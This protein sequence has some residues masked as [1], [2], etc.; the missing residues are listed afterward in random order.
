MKFRYYLRGIGFGIIFAALVFLVAFNTNKTGNLSDDEIRERAKK[1]G[2][3]EADAP[4]KDLINSDKK[5]DS[6]DADTAENSSD[7]QTAADNTTTTEQTATKT[8]TESTTATEQ[9]STKTEA[10]KTTA[11]E[12]TTKETSTEKVTT[13]QQTTEQTTTSEDNKKEKSDDKK[14]DSKTDKEKQVEITINKGS[15]SYPVC[16]KLQ[17]LGMIDDAAKFDDY[18]IE[19]GYANRI[20][21][22]THKLTKGM[23]YHTIAE[24]ISDPI[25]KKE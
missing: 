15:S 13:E 17:E 12:E 9:V 8:E 20:S 24:L 7:K 22:G 19:H 14:A 4:I 25:D 6:T 3:V 1:L 5:N 18:L 21:V 10:D 16:Q 11:A 2:M 23:D